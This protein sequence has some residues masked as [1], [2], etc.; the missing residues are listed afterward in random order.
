MRKRCIDEAGKRARK[1]INFK[2]NSNFKKIIKTLINIDW[3]KGL[4]IELS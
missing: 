1:A 3:N 2:E 4:E